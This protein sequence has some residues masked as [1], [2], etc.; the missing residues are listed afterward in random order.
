MQI[1]YPKKSFTRYGRVTLFCAIGL[2]GLI[3]AGCGGGSGNG[4]VSTVPQGNAGVRA[5]AI[6]ADQSIASGRAFP[7]AAVLD[8]APTGS[9]FT[10][11]AHAHSKTMPTRAGGGTLVF[12]PA[13][14]LYKTYTTTGNTQSVAYYTD[15]A[16]TKSA[17][18]ASMTI[19]GAS[20]FDTAYKAYP[21]TV[22]FTA[23]VTGGTLPFN[24]SGT[25]VFTD[26][27]GANSLTGKF[28]LPLNHVVVSGK[29]S[30]DSNS[31]VSGSVDVVESGATL[32]VTN[33][34]GNLTSDVTGA[35]SSDPYGWK[36]TGTFNLQT[37]KFSITLNTGSG[38]ATAVSD[39]SGSLTLHFA[40][41][42]SQ[43][44]TNPLTSTLAGADTGTGSG[45]GANGGGTTGTGSTAYNAPV[46]LVL[47]PGT[48]NFAHPLAISGANIAIGQVA[49]GKGDI[50]SVAWSAPNH[51]VLLA[52][53]PNTKDT[54]TL[55]LSANTAQIVGGS[56][57]FN[58]YKPAFWSGASNT[59][60]ALQIGDSVVGLATSINTNGQI[61][62][63]GVSGNLTH[64]GIHKILIQDVTFIDT[65]ALYWS[66]VAAAPAVLTPL[67]TG[68][69]AGAIS[70]NDKG[71]IVGYAF[72][73]A[74]TRVPVYWSSPSASPIALAVPSGAASVTVA[75]IDN[76]GHI[77]G[78]SLTAADI[79][80]GPTTPLYW[81]S[82]TATPT[83][84]PL[85]KGTVR[86]VVFGLSGNGTIVG[87]ASTTYPQSHAV[88]WKNQQVEDL[89]DTLPADSPILPEWGQAVN[90]QGQILAYGIGNGM[91]EYY[92]LT[93]K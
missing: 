72:N 51:P 79:Y 36:G 20:S 28:T 65:Q 6:A 69:D 19:M 22:N 10:R 23:N 68:G 62:G 87:S 21:V 91:G 54:D 16:G 81:S 76:L 24:G 83:V 8:T 48:T 41:G 77:A 35:I 5:I 33:L 31:N 86:G 84:L 60:Q 52:P 40:D 89:T 85:P 67:V 70:I 9:V 12:D 38:T 42:T 59:P 45:S 80:S 71:Q 88:V 32:H 57:A 74:G 55:A 66:S 43:T 90:D 14:G 47:P 2:N 15:A 73:A 44:I 4:S 17:G 39:A 64:T 82:P 34:S 26:A 63:L 78:T 50:V 27:T 18:T 25:V 46:A 92:I 53:V 29:L 93:P 13:D 49:T 7:L 3:L 11:A 56:G 58:I 37:G 30:L 61:V 1:G 75:G